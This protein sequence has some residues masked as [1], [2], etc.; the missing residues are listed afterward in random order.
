[1]YCENLAQIFQNVNGGAWRHRTSNPFEVTTHFQ[2]VWRANSSR[3]HLP[4][5]VVTL[6]AILNGPYLPSALEIDQSS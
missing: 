2:C 6:A 3:I 4:Q 5:L 1:M